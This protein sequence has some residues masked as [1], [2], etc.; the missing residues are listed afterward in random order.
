M[1][2]KKK[3]LLQKVQLCLELPEADEKQAEERREESGENEKSDS[4]VKTSGS[5]FGAK[6]GRIGTTEKMR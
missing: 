2:R 4:F 6:D 3:T 1:G 5:L